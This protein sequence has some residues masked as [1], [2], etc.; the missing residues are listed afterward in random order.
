MKTRYLTVCGMACE[1]IY[2]KG[3]HCDLCDFYPDE[4]E[5][6]WCP[7]PSCRHY[8][9]ETDSMIGGY[10]KKREKVDES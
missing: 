7:T 6:P 8:D 2:T 1:L 5:G 3:S 4:D 9:C 10:L